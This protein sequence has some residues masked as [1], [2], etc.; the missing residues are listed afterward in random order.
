M[1]RPLLNLQMFRSVSIRP[2]HELTFEFLVPD[3]H[4]DFP[5]AKCPDKQTLHLNV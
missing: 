3:G 4:N 5:V 1:R 2:R